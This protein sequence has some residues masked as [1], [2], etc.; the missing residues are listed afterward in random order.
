[1]YI[2]IYVNNR[3]GITFISTKTGNI[4]KKHKVF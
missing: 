4:K 2:Y 1:M 3:F